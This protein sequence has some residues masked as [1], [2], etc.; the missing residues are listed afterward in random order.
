MRRTLFCDETRLYF[1]WHALDIRLHGQE[2]IGLLY[3][4]LFLYVLDFIY[5][6][7]KLQMYFISFEYVHW[8]FV[9]YQN[10]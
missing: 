7:T 6:Q 8:I 9:N 1:L 3:K 5:F 10:L 2:M 4:N